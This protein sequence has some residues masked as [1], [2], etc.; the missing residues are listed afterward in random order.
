[1]NNNS[2]RIDR[3]L[4]N[5][6]D[7]AERT[8]FEDQ[9]SIDKN[10]QEELSIQQQII[11]AATAAG[12]KAAFAN[13]ILKKFITRRLVK[14]GVV[15]FTA[16]LLFYAIKNKLFSH[17]EST[18][19]VDQSVQIFDINNAM[20]T[21][22]E[23]KD[24]V[25][26]AIPAQ[27]FNS[28]N[29]NIRLEIKTALSA[30]DILQNGLST[31]SN[32][33]M[34]QTGGMFCINGFAD[35]KKLS[36]VKEIAV[37]IPSV[38]INSAMQLFDGVED[39]NGHINWVNPRPVDKSLRTYDISTLDFYPPRYIPTLKALEKNFEDKHYTDSLYYSFSGYPYHITSP[40]SVKPKK[41]D[42][43]ES[44]TVDRAT[45]DSLVT[46][47]RD[48]DTSGPYA[49]NPA[50][51]R[52]IWDKK[53]NNT[54]IATKEFEERLRYMH[55]LCTSFYLELYIKNTGKP[56]YYTDKLCADQSSGEVR[57]KF[58]DFAARKEGG[59]MIANGLEQMLTGYFQ[60]KYLG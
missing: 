52:A 38:K 45:F 34:L 33:A 12:L 20:D 21:V 55:S 48:S 7:A 23:T 8:A 1:M 2:I 31:V 5:E 29:N 17:Q 35:G 25:V 39:S 16:A 58:L 60:K 53:F 42:Y 10:L 36:L 22:I 32:D 4:Q 13:A 14:W 43:P 46:S 54:I 49:I 27:A 44:D 28:S 41:D 26:F 11:K 57:K 30:Y 3:Y 9:L 56:L 51:I 59:V 40:D 15:I 37:S 50:M 47:F 6:M 24:A 19:N 18:K